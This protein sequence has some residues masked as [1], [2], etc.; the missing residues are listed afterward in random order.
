MATKKYVSLSKLETF[1][2][3]L[4]SRFAQISH[5]HTVSDIT[6]YSIDAELSSTSTNPVQNKVLDSEFEAIANSMG[7]LDL[8]IDGKADISHNHNDVYYTK[9]EVDNMEFITVEDI[10]VICGQTLP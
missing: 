3:K 10:D 4:N 1:L 9:D 5:K 7:A 6:D 8:A 2:G